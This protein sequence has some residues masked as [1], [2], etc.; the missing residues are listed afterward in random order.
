M[1]TPFFDDAEVGLNEASALT[2]I[3]VSKI[4][5]AFM[6]GSLP[7][8]RAEGRYIRIRT[9]E[10][11]RWARGKPRDISLLM[12]GE[13]VE[14]GIDEAAKIAG[15]SASKIIRAF[16]SGQLP[17]HRAE[18]KYVRIRISELLKWARRTPRKI[19]Q[20]KGASANG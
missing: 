1:E 4:L 12:K 3:K 18:G 15:I 7:G 14:V 10:L 19:S 17:G 16:F 13:D 8:Y 11:L 20:K 2:H 5:W 9:S 6:Q